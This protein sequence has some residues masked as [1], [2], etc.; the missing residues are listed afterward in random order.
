MSE[1]TTGITAR[2]AQIK[3]LQSDIESLQRAASVLE[4]GTTARAK[5]VSQ[6]KPKRRRKAKAKPKTTAKPK[7]HVWTA[8]EK[9]AIGRRMKA[10][11][12]KRRKASAPAAASPA[13]PTATQKRKRAPMSAAAKKAMSKRLKAY[14]AKRKK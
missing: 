5:A 4:G 14:W 1:I 12:A 3:Q 8:A 2:Q 13:Q 9:R 7:Q 11:W 10:Y 6:P